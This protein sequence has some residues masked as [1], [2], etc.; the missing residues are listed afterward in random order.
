MYD[1]GDKS[2]AASYK[3]IGPLYPNK[4]IITVPGKKKHG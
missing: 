4:K 2:L 3:C 1:G